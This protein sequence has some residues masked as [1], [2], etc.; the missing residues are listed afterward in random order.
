MIRLAAFLT[1][2]S[3]ALSFPTTSPDDRMKLGEVLLFSVRDLKPGIDPTAFEPL[4]SALAASQ[5]KPDVPVHL[6]R[7]DRGSRKGQY[8][9]V[10]TIDRLSKRR[11]RATDQT[12]QGDAV[13]YQLVAPEKVGPLPEV[14]V[15]GLHYTKVRPD[16]VEAFDRFVSEKLHPAVGNLRPDLRI[17]YYK[18]VRG[19]DAGSYIALVRAHQSLAR[20]ILAGRIRFRR[21]QGRVQAGPGVDE[22]AQ[23]LSWWKARTSRTRS[24]PPPCTRAASGRTSCSFQQDAR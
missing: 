11:A 3:L 7:A 21:P 14:D 1:A 5:S 19:A 22:R 6:F 8:V 13:E 16:R 10:S 9:L 15:L 24:L 23:H 4:L 20:Q 17:L 12:A 18:A 2:L